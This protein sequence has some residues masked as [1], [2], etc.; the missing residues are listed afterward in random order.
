MFNYF[1][2]FG[3]PLF[4]SLSNI[5]DSHLSNNVLTR[6][7]TIIFY[8]SLTN[9]IAIPILLFLWPIEMLSWT[10]FFLILLISIID[11]SYQIPY[12]QAMKHIDTSIIAALFSIGKIIVPILAYFMIWEVLS[13]I[14]YFWF[15][16]IITSNLFLT[17][18]NLKLFKI[19]KA[20]WLMLCVSLML[21]IQS[22]ISK[23]TFE[24]MSWISYMF[25]ITIV[26][27]VLSWMVLFITPVRRDII[28]KIPFY[29]ENIFIFLSNDIL[30][31]LWSFSWSYSLSSIP[32]SV[33]K[34]INSIQPLFVLVFW[35]IFNKDF[36]H[37]M[38]EDLSNWEIIKK[39]FCFIFIIIGIV[40]TIGG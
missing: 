29:R 37:L 12:Y 5:I 13:P 2:A 23:Y 18:Q 10:S 14:Q 31:Y 3:G 22:V 30:S 1:I 21:S 15:F 38:K 24:Y 11:V 16:I 8:N 6:V 36:N 26:S 35:I 28:E 33:F 34:A 4:H 27:T 39:I 19:N 17:I 20:F 40:L 7:E 9:F 32:V 25:Y